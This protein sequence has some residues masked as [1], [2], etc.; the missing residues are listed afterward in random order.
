MRRRIRRAAVAAFAVAGFGIAAIGVVSGTA[1]G[2][3]ADRAV[4]APTSAET[5]ASRSPRAVV[6]V[7][8]DEWRIDAGTEPVRAG[9]VTFE[10]RNAGVADHD[11]LIVRT[12]NPP[13]ALPM[14][15]EGVTPQLAGE[16]VLGESHRAHDHGEGPTAAGHSHAD[17]HL[18]RGD[19]RR[20]TISLEPGRYVLL[21]PIP[22]HYERGQH[23][24][25][26][27]G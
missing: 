21:C 19:R 23:A 17:R 11:L 26:T 15:L 5:D 12:D 27:V 14:G 7:E 4:T 6:Q 22:G 2:T 18:R 24:V 20:R 16:V 9:R 1:G 25:I 8:F 13:G 3:E 10:E